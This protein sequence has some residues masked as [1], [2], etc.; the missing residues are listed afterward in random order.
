MEPRPAQT[1]GKRRGVLARLRPVEQ[2]PESS[3]DSLLHAVKASN[4]KA[5]VKLIE[6]AYQYAA[7]SHRDQFRASGERFIEHPLEVARILA[8]LNMDTTTIVA[9]L[10]HDV[11]EDTPLS[12]E[13]IEKEFGEETSH[14]I[15][16][17]TK[18]DKVTFQ[19]KEAHQAE[20]IR[21]MIIA[22]ARDIRVL[23]IKLADRLHNMRTVGHLSRDTQELKARETLEIYA[24][25]AHRLGIHQI[26]WQ[27]EDLSFATLHPKQFDE[28]V[29]MVE[30]R[31]P[32]R[33]DVVEQVVEQL[34]EALKAVKIKS[35]VSGRPKHFWSIYQKMV[36]RGREFA[37]IYDLVGIRVTTETLRDCYGALGIIHSLWKP[38]PGRVKDY[39]AMPKF[40]MYQSLHTAVVGP[41]GK[42]LEIQI[43][44][45]QMHRTA[46]YGIAAH[47]KYKDGTQREDAELAWLR[48]MLDWQK[49][50]SDPREFME[51]LRI[52]LYQDEVFVFT[53]KGDVRAFPIGAAPIDFA[54]A[55]HTDVG[56]RCV[57][58]RVNG[59]LVPLTTEMQSGDTIEIITSKAAGAAPSQD[60]LQVVK[61]PRARN[62]IRQWFTRERREDAIEKGREELRAALRKAGLPVQTTLSSSVMSS[63]AKDLRLPSVEAMEAAIGAGHLSTAV[64]IQRLEHEVEGDEDVM[65]VPSRPV[66]M[67]APSEHGVVVQGVDDVLVRLARCCTPVPHDRIVGFV[68]RGRGVSVH[69]ADCPN[70]K[71]LL[72]EAERTIDVSWDAARSGSFTVGLMVQALDRQKLLRDVTTAISEM[73]VNILG[74]SSHTDPRTRTATLRFSVELADPGHLEHILAQIKRINA[75]YDASRIVPGLGAGA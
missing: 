61:T 71:A 60:W 35:T 29:R 74:S 55:I 9:A 75:V 23:L 64:V 21:K 7:E 50:L 58:A 62:K 1:D 68:T 19:S 33:E 20:T 12:I 4:P 48:Q 25:L 47:W 6:R 5:D 40:N 3:V 49:E 17:V 59:R 24:P 72:S 69:R 10:L 43:R 39:I 63:I 36:I 30:E 65:P 57:G 52:D 15:D 37:E 66:R 56:H 70:A 32:E 26:K 22:M 46:E 53:P 31:Q 51:S 54:Y 14:I 27:L 73:G 28:I 18:L 2:E 16:G 13:E 38:I 45:E 34:S 42:P 8:D 67:R 41:N 44:T 11:V